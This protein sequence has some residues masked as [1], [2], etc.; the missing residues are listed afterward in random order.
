MF[1]AEISKSVL[2]LRDKAFTENSRFWS[3]N[4]C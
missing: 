1:Y 2:I 3:M 4:M